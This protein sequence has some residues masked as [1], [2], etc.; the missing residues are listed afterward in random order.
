MSPIDFRNITPLGGEQSAGFEELC[1]QLARRESPADARFERKGTPDAGVECYCVLAGGGEWAWQAK[2][3]MSSPRD[4]QWSQIDHSVRV[5][6]DKHPALVRYHVCLPIDLPDARIEGRMSARQRWEEHVAKWKGW[7]GERAV[8][9]KFW[10]Q[11]EII[12]RLYERAGLVRYWFDQAFFDQAWFDKRLEVAVE[13]AGPRYTPELHVDLPIAQDFEL[14]ARS[15]ASVDRI[16]SLA[17]GIHKASTD[18]LHSCKDIGLSETSIHGIGPAASATLDG[19]SA[20]EYRPEEAPPFNNIAQTVTEFIDIVERFLYSKEQDNGGSISPQQRRALHNLLM[21]LTDAQSELADAGEAAGK[22]VMILHGDAGI[23]KTHLLCDVAK[24]RIGSGA[25]TILLMGNWFTSRDDPWKQARNYLPNAPAEEIIGALEAAAE[26]ANQRALLIIDVLN[27]SRDGASKDGE[28]WRE[29]LAHFLAEAKRSPWIGVIL[30]IRSGYEEDIIPEA[31]REGAWVRKHPGFSGQ[32]YDAAARFFSHYGLA[33]PSTPI[34]HPEF[35][36]PLFLKML[37]EGLQGSGV[38]QFPLGSIGLTEIFERYLEAANTRIAEKI[39]YDKQDN[40]VRDALHTIAHRMAETL[41]MKGHGTRYL[42]KKYAE[43]IA[44]QP[45]PNQPFSKSLYSHLLSEGLLNTTPEG[46]VFITYE[47]FADHLVAESL[48]DQH[49]DLSAPESAFASGG[50]LAFISDDAWRMPPGVIESLHILIPERTGKELPRIAPNTFDGDSY[51]QSLIWR[52]LDAFSEDTWALF[53]ESVQDDPNGLDDAWETMLT[54]ATIQGHMLNADR[55]DQIMRRHSMPHRDAIWSVS[56]HYM[57]TADE[58]GA[59]HRIVDWARSLQPAHD[60]EKAVVDLSA[61]ALA[62]MLTTSNRYLRDSATKGLVALLTGRFESAREFIERFADVDDPYVRERVYAV[63]YGVAM[64]S[65]DAEEVGALA[66]VVYDQIFAEG[67]PPAHILLRDY[68]R[69]VLERAIHLDANF[70]VDMKKTRPPYLSVWPAIPDEGE[71]D[72]L[73]PL[74]G[75]KVERSM[76]GILADFRRYV[77]EW[78]TAPWLPLRLDESAWRPPEDRLETLLRRLSKAEKTAWMQ[79]KKARL[80]LSAD[81]AR[82]A[83]SADLARF[84]NGDSL[85]P[86]ENGESDA[87]AQSKGEA[88]LK[89]LMDTLTPGHK[90]EMESIFAARKEGK[91]RFDLQAITRYVISR[92]SSLGWTTERFGYFDDIVSFR[93]SREARKPERIGKKYQWIALHEILAYLADHYQYLD[94]EDTEYQGPWQQSIRDI[95]PSCM[96]SSTPREYHATGKSWWASMDYH[97]WREEVAYEEWIADKTDVPN[98][99][100]L[101]QIVSDTDGTRWVNVDGYFDWMQ[102]SPPDVERY[103]VERRVLWTHGRGYFVRAEDADKFMQWAEGVNFWGRWMPEGSDYHNIF[104]G[105]YG[106]ADSFNYQRADAGWRRPDRN[107]CPI[108]VLPVLAEYDPQGYGGFDCSIDQSYAVS[109][110]HYEFVRKLGLKWSGNAGDYVDG[111]G[112]LAAFDPSAHK[113]GPRALLLREDLLDQYLSQEGLALFWL[114]IGEKYALGR[115]FPQS[116]GRLTISGAY[117][118]MS[119]GPEGSISFNHIPGRT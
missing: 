23:G 15:E 39:D 42:P 65:Y 115:A 68:A 52:R 73:M 27:E 32:E 77:I 74:V 47:R 2:Y 9:F 54:V 101:L 7:A 1:A 79:Y 82:L 62:W 69:G 13:S 110:P 46:D 33:F 81:F 6:L 99:K 16:K 20:L 12:E 80:A 57:W 45:L 66:K 83:L 4:A 51:R 87:D 60:A 109:L 117:Q 94:N 44:N 10:G 91:P 25:P 14:F 103:S 38:K 50:G 49:L 17:V 107:D 98:V 58:K 61:T 35:Q 113:A 70:D 64:R 112:K 106:W 104:I 8:E 105:E 19:L 26:T 78:Y 72:K 111:A 48:L 119:E 93:Q 97:N 29:H 118:Y 85:N 59:V 67:A 30:S 76:T 22:S 84:L 75:S 116:D 92:M 36:R 71:V 21:E 56:L 63:A 53:L 34:M 28:I 43:T 31:I 88:A 100:D 90:R 41:C 40:N 37:C 11:S 5:A 3:F 18:V 102:P 89:N 24:R 108:I 114:I 55:L 96:L 86:L 95:D